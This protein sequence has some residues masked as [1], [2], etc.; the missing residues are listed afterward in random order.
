MMH[1]P[2]TKTNLAPLNSGRPAFACD[3]L[4]RHNVSLRQELKKMGH[5][6]P[7]S[8]C[9]FPGIQ[10]RHPRGREVLNITGDHRQAMHQGC[11]RDQG[12]PI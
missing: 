2:F 8:A 1:H 4:T 12:I 9:L 10:Q 5:F 6:A 3:S 7:P 11:R